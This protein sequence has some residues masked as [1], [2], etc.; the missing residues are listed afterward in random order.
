MSSR[1]N[2]LSQPA[3]AGEVTHFLKKLA[4]VWRNYRVLCECPEFKHGDKIMSKFA[5]VRLLLLNDKNVSE[6]SSMLAKT[7]CIN[8]YSNT[9]FFNR[10]LIANVTRSE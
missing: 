6:P 10:H 8:S 9:P 4:E 3:Q 1:R 7:M 2:H 5:M